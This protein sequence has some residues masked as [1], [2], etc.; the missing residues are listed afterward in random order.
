[1]PGRIRRKDLKKQGYTNKEIRDA[2]IAAM[3]SG[4]NAYHGKTIPYNTAVDNIA[5]NSYGKHQ[6][7]GMYTDKAGQ[8]IY[9]QP[10]PRSFI[11]AAADTFG[12][13]KPIQQRAKV[14]DSLQNTNVR[15]IDPKG[16]SPEM[17]HGGY[18]MT[19]KMLRPSNKG[20]RRCK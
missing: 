13:P 1:M 2:K 5:A 4:D 12:L 8:Q 7:T 20:S 19:G 14:V 16:L 6:N 17:K 18:V 11:N 3:Q 9:H 10:K 15:V